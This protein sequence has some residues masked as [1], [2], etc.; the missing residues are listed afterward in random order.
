MVQIHQIVLPRERVV[1]AKSDPRL[2]PTLALARAANAVTL[3]RLPLLAPTSDM[4]PSAARERFSALFY[5]GGV[6]FEAL[7]TA[8]RSE[9]HFDSLDQW[10]RGFGALLRDPGVTEFRQGT[11]VRFRD[12]G[13]FHFD[14]GFFRKAASRWPEEDVPLAQ[15]ASLRVTDVFL[16]VSDDLL[17][18]HIL[19]PFESQHDMVAAFEAFSGSTVDLMGRFL[20]STHDLFGVVLSDLGADVRRAQ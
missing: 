14:A 9:R 2:G 7:R 17:F 19:G 5:V 13:T 12:K 15:L 16:S 6:L 20:E 10:H 11:L 8:E 18:S 1:T 3:A 4:R